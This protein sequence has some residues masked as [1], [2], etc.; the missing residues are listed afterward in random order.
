LKTRL[1]GGGARLFESARAWDAFAKDY[2]DRKANQPQWVQQLLDRHF[3][4]AYAQAL[5]RAKRNTSAR[6][7]G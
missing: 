5:L 2:A 3:T 1:L 6:T 4:R 7:R